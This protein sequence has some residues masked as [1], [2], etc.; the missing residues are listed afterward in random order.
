MWTDLWSL[1]WLAF[2]A[3]AYIAYLFV[4]V[5]ILAD[6]FRDR[7]L[8]GGIKAIWVIFLVFLPFLTAIVYLIARGSGMAER[9]AAAN[10]R[11]ILSENREQIRAASFAS[12]TEEIA[13]AQALLD[14]GSITA[15]EFDAIKAKALGSK[16]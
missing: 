16:F 14:S 7:A 1:I 13:K 2:W 12:P 4:L 15:G 6:I 9:S 11:E 8:N 5:F 10:N 3:F